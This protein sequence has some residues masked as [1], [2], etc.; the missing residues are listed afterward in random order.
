VENLPT[1]YK[2]LLPSSAR[3]I[4][5]GDVVGRAIHR[6]WGAS[7]QIVALLCMWV[8]RDVVFVYGIFLSTEEVSEWRCQPP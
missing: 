8:Q 6:G 4:L 1:F 5:H 3:L 7:S 2:S